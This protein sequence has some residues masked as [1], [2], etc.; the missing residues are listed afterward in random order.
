MR[1]IENP[2]PRF[3]YQDLKAVDPS[4]QPIPAPGRLPVRPRQICSFKT[5]Q[6]QAKTLGEVLTWDSWP[7]S[8]CSLAFFHPFFTMKHL[9]LLNN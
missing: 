8:A 6:G 3:S 2:T 5:G 7:C 4:L 1:I 9:W